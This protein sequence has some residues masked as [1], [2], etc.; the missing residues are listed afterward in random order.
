MQ[1][2]RLIRKA[3]EDPEVYDKSSFKTSEHQ[4]WLVVPNARDGRKNIKTCELLDLH[5]NWQPHDT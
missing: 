4:N 1:G 3:L 5:N 2:T